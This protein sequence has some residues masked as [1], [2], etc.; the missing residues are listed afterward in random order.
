MIEIINKI[1]VCVGA[2]TI[3]GLLLW[4]LAEAWYQVFYWVKGVHNTLKNYNALRLK[5]SEHNNAIDYCK[6][7]TEQLNLGEKPLTFKGWLK[8]R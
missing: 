7:A 1:N 4:G 5:I 8:V 6:Y 2:I 3:L